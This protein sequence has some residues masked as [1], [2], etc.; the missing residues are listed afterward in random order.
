M[1]FRFRR[2]IRVLPFLRLNIGKRG[3]SVS[4]GG[5]GAHVT[6]G[7]G[8]VRE[9]VGLPGTGLSYTHVGKTHGEGAGAAPAPVDQ[10]HIPWLTL[11][12]LAGLLMLLVH[13]VRHASAA[14]E[15]PVPDIHSLPATIPDRR[16]SETQPVITSK[17]LDELH[18]DDVDRTQHA[19]NERVTTNAT[20]V[21]A[22]FTVLLWAANIWLI[23]L[24]YIASARQAK[25]TQAAIREAGR[26]ATAMEAVA[27]ATTSNAVMMREIFS[28]QMR[29][30]LSVEGGNAW[31]QT[32]TAKFQGIPVITNNG[33]TPAKNVGWKVLAGIL[34]GSKGTPP[35]P[36][37]GELIVSDMSIAPRQR[38]TVASP[39]IDRVSD[40]EAE[41]IAAGDT[42]RVFVWGR[43]TYDDIFGGHWVTNFCASYHFWMDDGKIMFGITYP[44]KHNDST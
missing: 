33:L 27:T 25:E 15:E 34:D 39:M 4:I 23:V 31:R 41:L 14:T 9:T 13:F 19:T 30:Y 18:Q 17:P 28:K 21:L 22:T 16:G 5:R 6:L 35:L 11:L 43:V 40:E 42:R 20:I 8:Q 44:P 7:H 24:T 3:A 29:A 26:S 36:E 10:R 1:G 37:I 2:S 32:A 38:F 12:V